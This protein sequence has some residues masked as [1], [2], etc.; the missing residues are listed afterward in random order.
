MGYSNE[1]NHQQA[2]Y[3]KKFNPRQILQSADRC[4]I[5]GDSKHVE[6]FQ[7]SAHKYLCGNCH[8]FGNFS[9]L[10]YKKQESYKKSPRSPKE[11][12]LTSGR[13]STQDNSICNHSSDNS[14]SVMNLSA[15]K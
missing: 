14:S 3:K 13:L 2:Q 7:C 4:H 9:S 1:A 15:F 6:A 8:K 11:Y 5:C 10:C 12:Q